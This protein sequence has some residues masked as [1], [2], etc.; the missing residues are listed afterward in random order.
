VEVDRAG[1]GGEMFVT[2]LLAV[3][4][5]ATGDLLLSSAGHLPPAVVRRRTAGGAQADSGPSAEYAA[6]EP[7]PPLGISGT[8]P[9]QQIVLHEGDALVAFTGGLLERHERSLAQGQSTLLQSLGT[10]S[11]TAARS[12]SQHVIDTLIGD[13]GLENDCALLVVVRDSRV[14]QMASVLVPPHTIAVRGARRWARAQ[15]ESWGVNEEIVTAAVIC[16]SELVTN[17]VQHAG[18]S[19]RVTMELADRLLVTVEDTGTWSAPRTGQVDH[20]ASQG[21]G[22]ALVAGVSDAM[23]QARGVDG[24]TVWFEIALDREST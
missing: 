18:T 14:H 9:I 11:A 7:G 5:P 6:L 12:I 19:A 2:A 23:G 4:D 3:F 15:L 16:V 1:F 17:V 13:T 20:S 22:L 10:M 8:R 21:R 24:S